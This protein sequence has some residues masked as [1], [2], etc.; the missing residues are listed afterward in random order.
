MEIKV[1]GGG[2]KKCHAL[3]DNTKK[4]LE[5]L[6]M[7]ESIEKVTETVDIIKA[8]VM[9]TPA[10]VIDNKI[11]C[12]GKVAKPKQIVEYIKKAQG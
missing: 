2:C 3:E 10:L 11:V 9:S 5:E 7:N 6:G 12:S 1:L 4:A 8:G